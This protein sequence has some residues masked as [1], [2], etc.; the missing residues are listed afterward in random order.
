MEPY[1]LTNNLELRLLGLSEDPELQLILFVLFLL[2]YLL[3]VLGNVLIIVAISSDSHLHSPMYFFLYHLSLSDMGFSSTT[4]PK[5]LRNMQINNKS[6]TYAACLTQVTFF[7]LFGCMDSLLLTVMPYDRWVAICHPLHYQ[8]IL[9]PCQCKCLVIVSFCISLMDSQV[10]CLMVSQLKF[11]TNIEI[12]H[13]FCDVPELLRLACSDSSTNNIVIFLVSII[14]G[15]LPASGIFY[16]Y[17]KIISS[18]IRVPSLL[19]KYKAF[20]TCGYLSIVYLFYGTG[21]GVYLSSSISSS[22]K[23]SVVASVMYTMVVPMMNPFIYSLRNRDIKKALQKSV[24]QI[25]Y[26][27]PI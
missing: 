6:I 22:P 20:S 12:P 9:N 2:I 15:F 24:S 17:Y 11:C 18:I 26:Y 13:F 25:T 14:V 23:D 19:G 1:N 16:S 5:M 3:T 8:V 4:I 27:L 7:F 10:H 21:L